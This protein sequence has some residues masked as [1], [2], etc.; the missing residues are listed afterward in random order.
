MLAV[1][2]LRRMGEMHPGI[3][4]PVLMDIIKNKNEDPIVRMASLTILPR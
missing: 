1:M 2:S 3:V 4:K